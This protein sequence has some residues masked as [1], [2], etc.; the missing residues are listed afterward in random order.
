MFKIKYSYLYG[1]FVLI[2][3]FNVLRFER[4]VYKTKQTY[5]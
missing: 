1:C 3:M 5:I 2:I 4:L